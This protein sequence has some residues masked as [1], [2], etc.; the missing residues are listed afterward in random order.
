MIWLAQVVWV[1]G[2]ENFYSVFWLV[3]SINLLYCSQETATGKLQELSSR[4]IR[5]MQSLGL[6]APTGSPFIKVRGNWNKTPRLQEWK[7]VGIWRTCVMHSLVIGHA[8]LV[9]YFV[10]GC[11]ICSF[12]VSSS[13]TWTQSSFM[14]KMCSKT[15]IEVGGLPLTY[16]C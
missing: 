14:T 8:L 15:Y 5:V 4:R 9:K 1:Y 12:E 16:A 3:G 6:S 2:L 11:L 7:S 10:E 13:S